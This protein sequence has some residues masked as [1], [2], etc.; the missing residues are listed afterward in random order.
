MRANHRV[1]VELNVRRRRRRR[2]SPGGAVAA[3]PAHEGPV[4]DVGQ[5]HRIAFALRLLTA[6]RVARDWPPPGV[7]SF[8]PT[9]PPDD[10]QPLLT[11]SIRPVHPLKRVFLYI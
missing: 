6:S 4:D 11:T 9:N 5:G 7:P 1:P 2:L 8:P 10:R 3:A